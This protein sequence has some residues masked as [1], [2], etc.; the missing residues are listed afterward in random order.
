[1]PKKVNRLKFSCCALLFTAGLFGQVNMV[2]VDP[3]I[4][5]FIGDVSELDRSKYF[6]MHATANT[7][8]LQSFYKDYNVERSCL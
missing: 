8:L 7:P 4:Q 1:M 6:S 2:V 3:E 5:K